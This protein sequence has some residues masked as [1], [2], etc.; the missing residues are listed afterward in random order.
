MGKAAYVS[1]PILDENIE[2][3]GKKSFI[4]VQKITGKAKEL[5]RT[6]INVSHLIHELGHVFAS[7]Q[8]EYSM[9]D[10]ILT[11]R[12]GTMQIKSSFSKREDGK[13]VQKWER[14]EGVFIEEAMNS[15]GEEEAMANYMGI[16][17]EEMQ[18][19]YG[20]ILTPTAYQQSIC[21]PMR[22]LQEKTYGQ[23]FKNWRLHGAEKSKQKIEN[24]IGQTKT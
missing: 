6:D 1:M 14:I 9:K 3:K 23:D 22:D 16:S 17:L 4:Y 19:L 5:L 2:L 15:I 12:A 18:K 8:E 21:E 10:G 20:E 24:L 11:R 13:V 7:Q